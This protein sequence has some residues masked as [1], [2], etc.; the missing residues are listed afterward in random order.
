MAESK[1]ER[2]DRE[3]AAAPSGLPL[4]GE[5]RR[6]A[7]GADP[8][9]EPE[10][11]LRGQAENRLGVE[12]D[13]RRE[14]LSPGEAERLIQELR[15]HQIELELQ[16]EELQRTRD[17]LDVSRARYF[18]L[19][20]LAPVGYV[21]LSEKGLILEANL[22]AATLLGTTRDV[23]VKLPLARFIAPEDQD[24]YYAYR[25]S[26]AAVDGSGAC[27]VRLASRNGAP[28]WIRLET[29]Q[30]RDEETGELVWRSTM[31]DISEARRASEEKEKLQ[32][33]LGEAQRL[34][35]VGRL[36]GGV[37]HD[38]NNML[39]VILG[40]V[41]MAL[42][43]VA[44]EG[45]LH[46]SLLEIRK[47]ARRSADLTA[48]LLTFARRQMIR[49]R[50]LDLNDTVTDVV[51]MLRRVIREDIVLAWLPGEDLWRVR[52]DPA[53]IDQLV[54]NL[55]INARDSIVGVGTV[56]IETANASLDAEYCA[57][58]SGARPGE[59]VRLAVTDTG[60]G[61]SQEILRHVFEP[62]FTTKDVGKGTGLGLASVY[63]IVKQN[64]G[65]VDARSEPGRGTTFAVYF[66]RFTAENAEQPGAEEMEAVP[67]GTETVILVEDEVAML[68]F[69]KAMLERLGYTVLA[70][71][72]PVEAMRLVEE[73]PDDIQ[74]L[75]TD[76]VMPRMSGRELAER[77]TRIRPHLKV[78]F[79]SGYGEAVI[80]QHGVLLEGA[81]FIRKP[82]SL[83]EMAGEIRKALEA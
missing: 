49:P 43:D 69:A 30:G 16:N 66:P 35:S 3:G 60:G 21:T 6:D 10:H 1:G 76:V 17:A 50:A 4:G 64:D 18:D 12:G 51:K 75:V 20:D 13:D 55:V 72:S 53:Q 31:S 78:L 28:C 38:F 67:G 9:E 26:L 23:L 45:S 71:G 57:A 40:Y 25:R 77:L 34:D 8:S 5:R 7:W 44:P 70:A 32:V 11:T 73:C 36:A 14:G 33:S 80:A 82:F 29:S 42:E 63:G 62:F 37:A 41:E 74:L 68:G 52:M 81:R 22:R 15:V 56:T 19:Y 59:Y 47:A 2:K 58:H 24:L 39:G 83:K 61:M 79:M 65:M 27:E 46:A 54:A 48:Q